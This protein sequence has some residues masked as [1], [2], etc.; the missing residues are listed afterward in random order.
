MVHSRSDWLLIYS[1]NF[2]FYWAESHAE[3]L[4][5][6]MKRNIH[7]RPDDNFKITPKWG[8][9]TRSTVQYARKYLAMFYAWLINSTF[10]WLN[11]DTHYTQ[12]GFERK[13]RPIHAADRITG[14]RMANF[15][16]N[17]HNQQT[18]KPKK[19]SMRRYPFCVSH[20]FL[21]AYHNP[22]NQT[23]AFN[24]KIKTDNPNTHITRMS[25]LLVERQTVSDWPDC[26]NF[27]C[28]FCLFFIFLVVHR[29]GSTG[30]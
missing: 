10:L 30:P 5:L 12:F 4:N 26:R 15:N 17:F 8:R 16:Q 13:L 21:F 11:G 22:D 6:N 20:V 23:F 2:N 9:A 14:T 3:R 18:R 28:Y 19:N 27:V 25:E 29:N 24:G 7:E 1:H